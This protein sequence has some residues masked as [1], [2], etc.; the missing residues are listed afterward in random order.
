MKTVLKVLAVWMFSACAGTA[1]AAN[2]TEEPLADNLSPP[3]RLT[4]A[5]RPIIAGGGFAFPFMGD[6]DNDGKLDLLVGQLGQGR[7][8]IYRNLAAG[9]RPKFAEAVDFEAGGDWACVP[10]G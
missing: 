3:V 5:G 4:A 10:F 6:F 1:F 2:E 8:Q 9:A 7:L